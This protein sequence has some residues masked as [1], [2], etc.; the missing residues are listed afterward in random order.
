MHRSP[1]HN[2]SAVP[3]TPGSFMRESVCAARTSS[4][5]FTA[6]VAPSAPPGCAREHANAPANSTSVIIRAIIYR[7]TVIEKPLLLPSGS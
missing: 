1:S 7:L 4:M 6:T 2:P 5:L 3:T